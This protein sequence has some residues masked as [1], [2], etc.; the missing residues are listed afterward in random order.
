MEKVSSKEDRIAICFCPEM[1]TFLQ[2]IYYR[3]YYFGNF[4]CLVKEILSIYFF[5]LSCFPCRITWEL[6]DQSRL[7]R[8]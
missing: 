5:M 8:L 3:N 6:F 4:Y 2:E 1:Q 7:K